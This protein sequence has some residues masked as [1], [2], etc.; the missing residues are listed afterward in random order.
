[1]VGEQS[2][3]LRDEKWIKRKLF[4]G[5]GLKKTAYMYISM[6]KIKE[7]TKHMKSLYSKDN[8]FQFCI[9]IFLHLHFSHKLKL[10]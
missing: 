4:L 7:W 2:I 8:L 9:F 1:M 5:K 10:F 3:D 6:E